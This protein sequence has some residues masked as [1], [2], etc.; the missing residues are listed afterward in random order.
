VS[1]PLCRQRKGKRLCPAKGESICAPCCGTKR[2]V[3]IDCPTDCVYLTGAHAPGW[4]G[5]ETERKRD[6]RRIAPYLQG[7]SE[8]QSRLFLLAL[9]GITGI[10]GRRKDL[11]DRLL[12]Q[13][14]SALKSTLETRERGILYDHQAQDVRA[15]GLV[16]EL[17]ELFEA[18]DDSG[19]QVAPSD[20]DLLPAVRALDTAVS[21]AIKEG[22]GATVFLDTAARLAGRFADTAPTTAPKPLIV[23]P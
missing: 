1:C 8:A 17:R 14:V 4:E 3:E 7:L 22:G 23:E 19:R 21:A 12:G 16:V 5:R 2:R 20:S 9:V 10:R 6:L 11:N 18:K 13:A 15:Q